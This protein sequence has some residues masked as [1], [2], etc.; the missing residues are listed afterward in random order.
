MVLIVILLLPIR[1]LTDRFADDDFIPATVIRSQSSEHQTERSAST[2]VTV[3]KFSCHLGFSC[4][5]SVKVYLQVPLV[6]SLL[7]NRPIQAKCVASVTNYGLWLETA[8]APTVNRRWHLCANGKR[9]KSFSKSFIITQKL[10]LV[11]QLN[12]CVFPNDLTQYLSG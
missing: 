1:V 10:R 4:L 8:M 9:W 5:Q 2:S 12:I 6:L 11:F 3:F 7:L